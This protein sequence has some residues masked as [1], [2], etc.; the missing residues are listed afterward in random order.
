MRGEYL[1]LLNQKRTSSIT[2]IFSDFSSVGKNMETW[3]GYVIIICFL[4][5]KTKV[6]AL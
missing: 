3:K 4:I 6:G 2:E 1:F 5:S